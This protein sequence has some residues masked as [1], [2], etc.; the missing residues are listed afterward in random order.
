MKNTISAGA[1]ALALCVGPAFAADL[2]LRE[3]PVEVPL[4]PPRRGWA[5]TS[6]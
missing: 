6:V 5:V 3:A 1:L 2:P 4:P